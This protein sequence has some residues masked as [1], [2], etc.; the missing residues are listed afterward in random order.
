MIPGKSGTTEGDSLTVKLTYSHINDHEGRKWDP[1]R[2][3]VFICPDYNESQ[4]ETAM[5]SD[6]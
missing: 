3:N 4:K 2:D 5:M 6:G 1:L